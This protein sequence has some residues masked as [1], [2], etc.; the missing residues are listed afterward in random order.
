MLGRGIFNSDGDE[1]RTQRKTASHMFSS[2]QLNEYMLTVFKDESQK[3]LHHLG[4]LDEF[5][6]IDMQSMFY[7]FTL[8]SICTIAFGIHINSLGS[9][10]KQ[11][12]AFATAF[13]N[14][15]EAT[16]LRW[17]GP[18]IAWKIKKLLK[19][20]PERHLP[21]HIRVINEFVYGV[22]RAR[23]AN[24]EKFEGSGD[25]LS[26]FLQD[27]KKRGEELSDETLRDIIMNFL[28]ADQSSFITQ[29]NCEE[30]RMAS[31]HA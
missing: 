5:D 2:R 6:V 17:F 29:M 4:K 23:R 16:T 24:L 13:D 19:I 10:D 20:G 21:E 15:Q 22:V 1:W 8:D 31:N 30:S 3:L 14:A 18:P 25:M 7:R 27:A 26:L 9:D 28:I 12:P 11:Q